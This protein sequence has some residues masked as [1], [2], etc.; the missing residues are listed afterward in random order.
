[1]RQRQKRGL[2]LAFAYWDSL[3]PQDRELVEE[4]ARIEGIAISEE[5]CARLLSDCRKVATGSHDVESEKEAKRAVW[6]KSN[7]AEY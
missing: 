3:S 4:L 7:D 2:I 5:N 1:M 6:A